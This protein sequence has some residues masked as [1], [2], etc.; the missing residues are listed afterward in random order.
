MSNT[1]S[2]LVSYDIMDDKRLRKTAKILCGYGYR[3]QKS[4]FFCKMTEIN[5]A[6][7]IQELLPIIQKEDD[8]VLIVDLG[9]DPNV[10]DSFITIGK[11]IPSI[12]KI[13]II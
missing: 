1:R 3:I 8:Q 4:V 12:T 7:L 5:R 2:Y 10:I 6:T 11:K 13:V 9:V